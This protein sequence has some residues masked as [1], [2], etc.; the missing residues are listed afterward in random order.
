VRSQYNEF[1]LRHIDQC[2]GRILP[3]RLSPGGSVFELSFLTPSADGMKRFY[4]VIVA[5]LTENSLI[6]PLKAS[7][8]VNEETP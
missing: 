5:A 2:I 7:V 6:T 4:A 8:F 1:L 3:C